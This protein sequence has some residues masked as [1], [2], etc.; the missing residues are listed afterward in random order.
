MVVERIDKDTLKSSPLDCASL[1]LCLRIQ[2]S[3]ELDEWLF[4]SF[5]RV[6]IEM[7]GFGVVVLGEVKRDGICDFGA[8]EL[9]LSASLV[10]FSSL[11]YCSSSRPSAIF[12]SCD[13]E[14]PY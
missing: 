3:L 7:G 11:E 1:C 2:R 13:D 8:C 5:F 14:M 10:S 12:F 6:E 9:L 4:Q